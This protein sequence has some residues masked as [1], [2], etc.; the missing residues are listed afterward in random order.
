MEFSLL[1]VSQRLATDAD[2]QDIVNISQARNAALSVTGAL[3]ASRSFFAQILEGQWAA[4]DELMIS[5]SRDPRHTNVDVLLHEAVEA[6]R[7][8]D[9]ALAYSGA[10]EFIDGLVRAVANRKTPQP[11]PHHLRRLICAMEEFTRAVH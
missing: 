10:S 6:R 4:I 11:D 8:P 5:I 7:F 1:Y 9:W 3:I 2:V